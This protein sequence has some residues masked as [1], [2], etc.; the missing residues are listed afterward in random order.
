MIF[1]RRYSAQPE[2]GIPEGT[3]NHNNATIFATLLL[4]LVSVLLFVIIGELGLRFYHLWQWNLS[5]VDGQFR[6]TLNRG[7]PLVLDDQLGWRATE[8]YRF[9]GTKL[10]SDGTEYRATVS[11]NENGFRMF[12]DVSSTKRR[13]FVIGDSFTQAVAASDDKTY[14]AVVKQLLDLEVFAYGAGG[15]GSLQEFM[16]LDKYFD[17]IKPDLI[18]WQFSTN[19]FVNNSPEMETASRINNNGMV[20]PYLWNNQIQS[21][22]PKPYSKKIRLFALQYCRFCYT[23][24]TRLDRLDA[25]KPLKTVETETFIGGPSHSMFIDSLRVT[26]AIM[27]RVRKRAGPIPIFAFVVGTGAPYG[28]EYEEGLIEISRHHKIVLLDDIDRTVLTA[29]K[30]GVI[31]RAEDGSHWNEVGH[32]IAG[33]AIANSLRSAKA[34][35]SR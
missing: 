23:I 33:E 10:S 4:P 15:Y 11:Q 30:A 35:G 7:R 25:V 3:P 20:R 18:L 32:R 2:S 31:A 14:Y 27:E 26:D 29:E 16:I 9:E 5:M 34:L 13:V 6:T 17:M 12:G 1:T 8:N 21:I 24:L 22:L 19:D 28:P